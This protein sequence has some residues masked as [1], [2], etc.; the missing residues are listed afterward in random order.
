MPETNEFDSLHEDSALEIEPD[1]TAQLDVDNSTIITD[2]ANQ[3][4]RVQPRPVNG[5]VASGANPLSHEI[6]LVSLGAN[7]DS[8]YIGP[9]SG[10]FL[11]R[12]ML[13]KPP[14]RDY[15]LSKAEREAAFPS[16]LIE[17]LQGPAALP[18]AEMSK[19]LC[20]AYFE[21]IHPQY[22]ALHQP[23]FNRM[24]SQVYE[25]DDID[26]VAG[27]QV[28]MVMAI[29]ATVLSGRLKARIPGESFCLAAMR[30]FH[31][32]NIENS[33]QGLQCLIL[34][35]IFTIHSP[36]VR[37]NVWYLNYQCIASL[38][39]LGLQRDIT[40]QSG[41]TTLEQEM[42]TRIFWIVFMLDR[43]IGTM[44]GRPVGFRDEACELRVSCSCCV[45]TSTNIFSCPKD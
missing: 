27:F 38:I 12:V 18:A 28:Y 45:E 23:T 32:L 16:E 24:L 20:D 3:S 34:L 2:A 21:F 44:M 31:R 14:R 11:A 26:P 29:G 6:G 41:I 9:S 42:R 17:A 36:A 10:Y 37:L 4:A 8:R 33:M 19:Q 7:Q 39:D 43:T 5:P 1:T 30:Y 40:T 22:P 13:T 25:Q 15:E 35:L